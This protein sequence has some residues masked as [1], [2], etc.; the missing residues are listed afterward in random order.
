MRPG[1]AIILAAATLSAVAV[2]AQAKD[3]GV[4]GATF[5]IAETDLLAELLARL[6]AAEAAGR[7]A[8][9]NRA[10]AARV[11]ARVNRPPPVAG[12]VHTTRPRSWLFDPSIRV[13]RD[14]A[15]ETG[16]IFAREG[17]VINPLDRIPDFNRVLIFIDGDDPR[18]VAFALRRAKR[19][20]SAR[21]Y[22]V[23]TAGAPVELMRRTRTELYFDQD[24]TLTARLGV[25]QVPA[26]VEREGRALRIS[27]VAP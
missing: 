20:L 18:Q 27:E 2:P 5:R 11:K 26:V 1:L 13:P 12:V 17:D 24:G 9:L 4:Y 7:M 3:F 19:D 25:T 6:K 21:S 23:L 16:R 15:D 14:F 8:S 22:I 10:F